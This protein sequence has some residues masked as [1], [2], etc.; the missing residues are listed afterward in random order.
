MFELAFI[1]L[2]ILRVFHLINTSWLVVFSPL[3]FLFSFQA[4]LLIYMKIDEMILLRDNKKHK[5]Y[6][7]ES[8][9]SREFKTWLGV[10]CSEEKEEFT[11][12]ING[13]DK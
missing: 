6:T 8:E 5:V 4:I 10:P 13:E 1:I 9:S 7:K 11:T 3:I 12:W 2:F